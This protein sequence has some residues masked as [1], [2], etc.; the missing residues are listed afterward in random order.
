VSSTTEA[1]KANKIIGD[2]LG[3]MD[4][5]LG[6]DR[7]KFDPNAKKP[8]VF[9]LRTPILKQG[10]DRTYMAAT[11]RMWVFIN[12]YGPNSGENQLHTHVNEDHTFIVLQGKARFFGPQGEEVLLTANEG[13][14][15]PR[16][17]VYTFCAEDG[18]LVLL[19]FGCV[20]DASKTPFGRVDVNGQPLLGNAAENGQIPIV[21]E[22]GAF[23][24]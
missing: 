16:G 14:M 8:E 24:E 22:D 17:T 11:D 4:R 15:L 3:T 21:F 5:M 1:P 2:K 7:G 20:V 23:Y 9:K 10:N 12:T 19:R 18:P 13:I 6:G